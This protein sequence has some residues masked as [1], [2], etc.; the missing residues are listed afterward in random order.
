[1][2]LSVLLGATLTQAA[3]ITSLND[4]FGDG[5]IATNPDDGNGFLIVE[6]TVSADGT[7]T[8]AD[9]YVEIA[10]GGV[11]NHSAGIVSQ[12]QLSLTSSDTLSV[13]WEI[14]GLQGISANGL[15]LNVQQG[16]TFRPGLSLNLRF[17]A[18]GSL[19]AFANGN[20]SKNGTFA[21]ADANDGFTATLTANA[22]GWQFD[23]TGLGSTTSISHTGYGGQTF[24]GLLNNGRV[25]TTFQGVAGEAGVAIG[26]VTAA[27]PEPAT[28]GL[29]SFFAA[30]MLFVR[31]RFMIFSTKRGIK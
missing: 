19:K 17:L 3:V 4:T 1:M 12:D 26:S 14:L 6:N 29:L 28:I 31:R 11:A 22:S 8:E 25:A 27:V 13:S 18:D 5:N 10:T 9:G 15:E 16:T 20:N 21:V 2:A 7:Y 24:D 30:G 23:F